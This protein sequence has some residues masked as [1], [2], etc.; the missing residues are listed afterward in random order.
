MNTTTPP[1]AIER[2]RAVHAAHPYPAGPHWPSQGIGP[3]WKE[4]R[5][6]M[7]EAAT[8]TRPPLSRAGIVAMEAAMV[9]AIGE[10][11]EWRPMDRVDWLVADHDPV[12]RYSRPTL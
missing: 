9:E 2:L 4:Y 8:G 10:P 6:A 5:A 3:R 12:G 7:I 1:Q 11:G